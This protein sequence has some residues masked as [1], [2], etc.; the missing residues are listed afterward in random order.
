MRDTAS[1]INTPP[2][3]SR[4]RSKPTP[5]QPRRNPEIPE[6][7]DTASAQRKKLCS[8]D[9]ASKED[10]RRSFGEFAHNELASGNGHSGSPSLSCALGGL[11]ASEATW[12]DAS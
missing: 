6:R 4:M 11:C 5:S 9:K 1:P 2:H 12:N 3:A 10:V 8:I 7:K